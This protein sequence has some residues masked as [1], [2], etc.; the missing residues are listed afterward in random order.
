MW[1]EIWKGRKE[2]RQKAEPN[3]G[4]CSCAHHQ[5]HARRHEENTDV[6]H[7]ELHR[8]ENTDTTQST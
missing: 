4:T 7:S 3:S 5:T 1:F 2:V 6:I 8:S